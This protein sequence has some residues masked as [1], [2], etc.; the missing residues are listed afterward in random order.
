MVSPPGAAGRLASLDGLRGIAAAAVVVFHYL[1]MFHH[2]W[3]PHMSMDPVWL[4]KTPVG[5]LWNGPFA[6]SVFF[7]LSGFVLARA[8][9]RRRDLIV[10]NLVTRYL[11]LALPATVSVLL[12]WLLLSAFPAATLDLGAG[13]EEPSPWWVYTV[14]DPV[15]GLAAA[16]ADGA[17]WTFLRGDSLFNNV[18]WTM[19]IELIGSVGIFV[20]YWLATG[21]LRIVLLVLVGAV[22]IARF[23][24]HYFAFVLGALLYEAHQRGLLDRLP[25]LAPLVVLTGAVLIGAPGPDWWR[26]IGVP[27]IPS[28]LVYGRT[29]GFAP[30]VFAAAIVYGA[31]TLP[32]AARLLAATVPQWLGRVSFGLYLVHVP[33]LY[34]LAAYGHG[35]AGLSL[36]VI[37][38][39]YFAGTLALAHLFTVALDEPVLRG[40]ARQRAALAPLETGSRAR[41]GRILR[42]VP[43]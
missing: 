7:A 42:F 29:A 23:P 9:E 5:L 20:V 37:A 13:A 33:P 26:E 2:H 43:K 4:S 22:I 11:R 21:R 16:I 3:I 14:Q 32:R 41:L 28:R 12:A 8:A 18:L 39:I 34:T 17:V 35:Q 27:W 19:Q 15:P 1:C 6:V 10:A 40:L 30:S 38:P 25:A 24:G 36:L 31:L